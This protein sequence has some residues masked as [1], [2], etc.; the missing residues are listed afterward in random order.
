MDLP[1]LALVFHFIL[2]CWPKTNLI[3][4]SVSSKGASKSE[5][6]TMDPRRIIDANLEGLVQSIDVKNTT[7][8]E[9]LIE[10]GI[11]SSS[12]VEY[13]KVSTGILLLYSRD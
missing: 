10:L 4:V 8:W 13:I 6:S 12:Y 2:V 7:L 11:F 5:I 1:I 3:H 9:R